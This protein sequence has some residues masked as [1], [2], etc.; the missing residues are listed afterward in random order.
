MNVDIIDD[1][2]IQTWDDTPDGL[3]YIRDIGFDV[4]ASYS[5]LLGLDDP[6]ELVSAINQI[7]DQTATD[8]AMDDPV[9][10]VEATAVLAGGSPAQA[11]HRALVREA[12]AGRHGDTVARQAKTARVSAISQAQTRVRD[13][14]KL[15]TPSQ[16]HPNPELAVLNETVLA[17]DL[18]RRREA[19]LASITPITPEDQTD[20]EEKD[21]THE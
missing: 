10:W 21:T 19:W 20:I 6:A 17:A 3:P 14:F 7:C 15:A 18:A 2:I 5:A 11:E 8:P 16:G 1:H 9:V 13:H 12:H 4:A